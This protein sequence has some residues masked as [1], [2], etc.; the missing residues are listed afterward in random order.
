MERLHREYLK[1]CSDSFLEEIGKDSNNINKTNYERELETELEGG[2]ISGSALIAVA[3]V[4]R[5]DGV[6][7]DLPLILLSGM[8]CASLLVDEHLDCNNDLGYHR[9]GIRS[10]EGIRAV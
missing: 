1:V 9:R 7:G 6:G 8:V 10:V 2:D 4:R 5:L 3:V